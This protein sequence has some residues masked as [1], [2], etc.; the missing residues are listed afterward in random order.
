MAKNI[1][2]NNL[3]NIKLLILD[4]DGVLSDGRI[5]LGNDGNEL[6]FFDV[7]DGLGILLLQKFGIKVAIITG[8]SS[9]L[10]QERFENLGIVDI[11]QGQKNKL[12]AFA[13]LK[14]KYSLSDCEVAYMGDDLPD[15]PIIKKVGFSA[16]PKDAVFEIKNTV[17]YIC[18]NLGGRGA[19]R[20]LCDIILHSKGLSSKIISDFIIYGEAR[21]DA[22]Q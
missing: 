15:L 2:H 10:V 19:V 14:E 1:E 20:E 16:S 4:V 8:K 18:E 9:N 12:V 6:K 7:K 21:A 17:D 5:V 22:L 13:N 11:Y 3:K